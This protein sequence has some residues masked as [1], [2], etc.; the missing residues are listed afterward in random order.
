[1]VPAQVAV[2]ADSVT[3]PSLHRRVRYHVVLPVG[4]DTA[5][6]YPVL[7]LLHGYG[8]NDEDWLRYTRLTRYVERYPIIVV[9]P[10]AENSWYVNAAGDS[11]ARYEDF[12][13]RDLYDEVRRRFAVDTLRQAIAGLS[14]GGYGAAMLGLRYPER[15]RFIGALS[16]ALTMP[17]EVDHPDP[18]GGFALPSLVRAFGREPNGA[19]A[20][21]DPLRLYRRIPPQR[22]P[23]IYLAIGTSDQFTTFLPRSRAFADSLRAYGAQYE[24]HERPGGHS[25]QFWDGE[26]PP[27][28]ART[29]L[30]LTAVRPQVPR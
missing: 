14:M 5:Q 21:H 30:E 27:L 28:L 2:R 4:Y 24:Y 9:L 15:F 17:T 6:R 22:L 10:S 11:S 18:N 12:I 16:A 29:W 20:A 1:L 8:G 25:W 23:Y 19:R 26:L 13:T 7:W 3:A